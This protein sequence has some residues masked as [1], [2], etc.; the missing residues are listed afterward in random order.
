LGG[1]KTEKENE[2]PTFYGLQNRGM[3]VSHPLPPHTK[4]FIGQV[5]PMV[6]YGILA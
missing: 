5:M 2:K 6:S 4:K 3:I 1:V